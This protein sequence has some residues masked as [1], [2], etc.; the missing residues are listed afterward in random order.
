MIQEQYE[1]IQMQVF[2]DNDTIE[3]HHKVLL[4]PFELIFDHFEASQKQN[5]GQYWTI[6]RLRIPKR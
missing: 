1:L 6:L 4:R 5:S 2:F 3:V